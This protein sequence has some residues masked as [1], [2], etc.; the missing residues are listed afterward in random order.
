[1]I[2]GTLCITGNVCESLLAREGQ[3]L[4][5]FEN[6]RNLA[7]SLC[8][9]KQDSR[10]RREAQSSTIPNPSQEGVQGPSFQ[11]G[12]TYSHNGVVGYPRYSISEMHFGK[13]PDS[14]EFQSLKVNFKTEVCASSRF[15]HMTMHWITEVEMA[16]SIDDLMTTR[17]ITGRTDF[18]DYDLLDAKIASDLKKI[19]TN[20]HS[21]R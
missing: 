8:E 9:L 7:L 14:M 2:H 18:P 11:A 12:E 16:K 1:M 6:S 21:R 15:P 19:I 5:S 17:S 20:M 3:S 10:M 4:P 13:F